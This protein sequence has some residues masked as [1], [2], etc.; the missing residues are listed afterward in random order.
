MRILK[1]NVQRMQE[2]RNVRGLVKALAHRD[3]EIRA[4][5]AAALGELGDA[6]AVA[7]LIAAL[8]DDELWV[9][10]RAAEALGKIGGRRAVLPLIGILND[11][12]DH[13]T[14]ESAARALGQIGDPAAVDALVPVL[15]RPGVESV[16]AAAWALG[17]LGD[18]QAVQPLIALASPG[19]WR[20]G[21]QAVLEALVAIGR[22]AVGPLVAALGGETAG[23]R[24]FAADVL[25]ALGWQPGP[26]ELAV[27]HVAREAWDRCVE[28]GGVAVEPLIATMR[29]EALPPPAAVRALGRIG[30]VRAVE[31]LIALLPRALDDRRKAVVEALVAIGEPAVEPLA[32]AMEGSEARGL[33]AVEILTQIGGTRAM[34]ALR[35]ALRAGSPAVRRAAAAALDRLGWRPG[36]DE[37]GA[38]YWIAGREWHRCVALGAVAVEPLIAV[39]EA[40]PSSSLDDLQ[41]AAEA[42]GQIGDVRA[43]RALVARLPTVGGYEKV[44]TAAADALVAIGAPAVEPLCQVLANPKLFWTV[45]A[46]VARV[47]ARIGD[48]SALP[49]LLAAQD[50]EEDVVVPEA[51]V[52]A[53]ADLQSPEVI[54]AL[55]EALRHKNPTVRQ[56]AANVLARTGDSRAVEP[57]IAALQTEHSRVR[58]EMAKALAKLYRE[59]GLDEQARLRI[60]SQQAMLSQ[61]HSDFLSR[62]TDYGCRHVGP[63][64]DYHDHT[65]RGFGVTL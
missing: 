28:L 31:P 64:T 33:A 30:D 12:D 14:W 42:L 51:A 4:D 53:L 22:P 47:L 24:A 55:I 61:P 34:E 20:S 58:L 23:A 43:V 15:S 39:L 65:D 32:A 36:R 57:L 40:K 45:R 35:A 10:R 11:P 3:E 1:P 56:A 50:D 44:G 2:K 26:D 17:R 16:E 63:H 18:P 9:R 13:D 60:L 41:H 52:R 59:G 27:Y 62:H 38:A 49:A 8:Q 7:P 6:A 5:A 29:G 48:P 21:R 54:P 46:P 25:D 37:E 19:L